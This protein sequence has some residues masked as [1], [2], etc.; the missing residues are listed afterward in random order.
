MRQRQ[1]CRFRGFTLIELLVVIAIIGVLIALLL[2]AVQQAREAARTAQCR[3][4]LK[5]IG[6]AI[7]NY[8]ATHESFPMGMV[9]L[10]PCCS[11]PS[12]G[13]WSIGLLPYI[14]QGNLYRQYDSTKINEDPANAFVRESRV[15]VYVCPTDIQTELLHVPESGPGGA[16]G[17]QY[18]RGSYRAVT[19]RSDG[20]DWWEHQN[21]LPRHWRGIFHVVDPATRLWVERMRDVVDGASR[22]LMMGEYQTLTQTNRRTFWAYAYTSYN[23]SNICPECGARTLLPSYTQCNAIGGPGG[24][25]SCKR[26]FASLHANGMHFLLADGS[27]SFVSQNVNIFVLGDMSTIQGSEET[28][29][30]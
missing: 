10:G 30:D 3:S 25:N 15:P 5:Q 20:S 29:L 14:D 9:T 6:V 4:N 13:T 26:S 24:I 16:M 22:T 21:G 19:G 17:I 12:Y 7:H 18:A 28:S 23:K 2:P 11:T 27:V 1:R 8:H